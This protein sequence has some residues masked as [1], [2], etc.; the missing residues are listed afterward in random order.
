MTSRLIVVAAMLVLLSA[1]THARPRARQAAPVDFAAALPLLVGEW[2]G[3]DA[4]PL[5]PAIAK[6]LAADQYVH[7]YYGPRRAASGSRRA[8]R[9]SQIAKSGARLA[10][11]GPRK[12]E[13]GPRIAE[14]ESR[15]EMDLA[16]Y[17][18][19]QAGAA[20]HSPLNCLP[21][22]GWQVIESRVAPVTLDRGTVEVRHLVVSRAGR[23]IAMAYWFQHRGAV[24]GNEYRQRLQLLVNGVRGRPADAALVRVMASDTPQGRDALARF[25]Q[26]LL[27]I[28]S[29]F[30]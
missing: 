27:G 22:N 1:W 9:A 6:V 11:S 21:G 18:Q 25:T 16:Y 13:S 30:T 14:S 7:R 10:E 24:V 26:Q 19:P 28:L 17:A 2:T 15:I 23:R 8:E 12:A 4:P 5:D 29:S 3:R 20:M